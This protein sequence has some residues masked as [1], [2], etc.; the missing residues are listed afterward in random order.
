[1]MKHILLVAAREYRQIASTRSFWLTL[2]IIP[3]A[4]AAG[5][6]LSRFADKPHTE[7][8]MLIDQSGGGVAAAIAHRI[9]LDRQCQ[10]MDAL[11]RYVVRHN[12][13]AVRYFL[14]ADADAARA[15]RRALPGAPLE[16]RGPD[17]RGKRRQ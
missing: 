2:L 13:E 15:D 3:L 5:P 12:L 14:R 11:S 4:L 1:M 6:L 7:T 10:V 17:L 16:S 9:E 8:V